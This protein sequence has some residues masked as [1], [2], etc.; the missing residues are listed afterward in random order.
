M[1]QKKQ[2]KEY[3]SPVVTVFNA[4]IEKGYQLS[5]SGREPFGESDTDGGWTET[6]G[7]GGYICS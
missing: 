6:L 3:V 7:A 5:A 4:R 2:K 1:K